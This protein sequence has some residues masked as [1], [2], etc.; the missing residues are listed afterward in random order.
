M[1][2][3][4]APPCPARGARR[5]R[6][7]RGAK[8]SPSAS[9]RAVT[10]APETP[11]P[12]AAP[13]PPGPPPRTPQRGRTHR[14]RLL[15]RDP[16]TGS[17]ALPKAPLTAPH[18]A[19]HTQAP[20]SRRIGEEAA[21]R[22]LL[23][24]GA[25]RRR[26]RLPRGWSQLSGASAHRQPRGAPA[27]PEPPPAV[28][29][30]RLPGEPRGG[31]AAPRGS[32]LGTPQPRRAPLLR[33]LPPPNASRLPG[34]PGTPAAAPAAPS[35][36][37]RG[38][39]PAACPARPAPGPRLRARGSATAGQAARGAAADGGGGAR[40]RSAPGAARR[41]LTCRYPRRAGTRR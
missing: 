14:R 11:V 24:G 13:D 19:P 29:G 10:C 31:A 6:F 18:S 25:R 9:H 7:P 38:R 3:A 40:G 30:R 22:M 16:E 1:C 15:L 23:A 20:V 28:P 37:P 2:Q 8:L 27:P 35:P 39:P 5:E 36:A 33:A 41:A 26:R 4:R 21:S 34:V 17:A 32:A 12:A